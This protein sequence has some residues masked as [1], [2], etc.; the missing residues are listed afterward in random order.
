MFAF[1]TVGV[2]VEDIYFV[3]PD[4]APGQEG[5]E[6]GVRLEV[7]LMERPG[8]DGS[9][10][11]SRPILVGRPLW[12]ADLL[13]SVDGAQG[14]Y[15]RTHH[16]PSMTG[17]E[18]GE[19]AFERELT[20]RPLQWLQERLGDIQDLL[21]AAGVPREQVAAP[22]VQRL[23]DEAPEIVAT[24]ERMLARVRSGELAQPATPGRTGWL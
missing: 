24:V 5:A 8:H 4:P 2:V 15:D 20:A 3:D 17:W 11:A 22:D 12:R 10:Y 23:H 18:P 13:E 14:S 21:D 9:M 1:E 16:H 7:R 19:R 6:R